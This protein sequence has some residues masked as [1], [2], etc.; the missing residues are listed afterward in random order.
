MPVFF[1]IADRLL[2]CL[3]WLLLADCV[4]SWFPSVRASAFARLVRSIS[5]PLLHPFR[6]VLPA[7]GG[8]DFSPLLAILLLSF[9][10]RLLHSN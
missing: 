10:Q 6:A 1:V 8:L 2:T 4:M 3:V 7:P 5:A 9:L